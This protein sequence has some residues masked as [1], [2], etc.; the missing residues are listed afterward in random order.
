MRRGELD[1]NIL[2]RLRDRIQPND[3][4]FD[5]LCARRIKRRRQSVA[6]PDLDKVGRN[7]QG[8]R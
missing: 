8:S 4:R 6:V 3:E 1:D 5:P 7:T 2:I